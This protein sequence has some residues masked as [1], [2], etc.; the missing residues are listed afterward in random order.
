MSYP[1][2]LICIVSQARR[3]ILCQQLAE[4][5]GSHPLVD[6]HSKTYREARIMFR[7]LARAKCKE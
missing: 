4:F 5:I 1:E 6:R 2:E 7:A 3:D